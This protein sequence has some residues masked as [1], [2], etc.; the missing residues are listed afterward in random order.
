MSCKPTSA[1]QCNNASSCI[2]C[3]VL[4]SPASF[5]S[6]RT[7]LILA[8]YRYHGAPCPTPNTKMC[9]SSQSP[10]MGSLSPPPLKL[11]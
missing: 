8:I 4:T 10:P 5:V 7:V 1:S 11:N 6:V 9:A 3:S 2:A